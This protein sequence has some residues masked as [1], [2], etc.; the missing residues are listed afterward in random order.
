MKK[1]F[2]LENLDCAVCAEKMAVAIR[3]LRGVTA[4]DVSFFTQKLTLEASDEQFDE[5][6]LSVKKICKKIEPDCILH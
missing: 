1:T 3:K 6:L 5:I 2:Q 4:A